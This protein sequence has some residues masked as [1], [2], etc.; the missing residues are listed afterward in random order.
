G[1]PWRTEGM[2]PQTTTRQKS[3]WLGKKRGALATEKSFFNFLSSSCT[4]PAASTFIKCQK[5]ADCGGSAAACFSISSNESS[6]YHVNVMRFAKRLAS[7]RISSN[8]NLSLGE[9]PFTT[10]TVL[11][12]GNT[13]RMFSKTAGKL[14]ANATTVS[15]ALRVE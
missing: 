4:T 2:G 12:S 11:V 13:R 1:P 3:V 5:I 15:F 9:F 8:Q 6:L 14:C 10:A 7:L